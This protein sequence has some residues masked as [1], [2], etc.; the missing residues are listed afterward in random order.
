[1]LIVQVA[2]QPRGRNLIDNIIADEEKFFIV[3]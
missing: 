2:V 1:M 3:H